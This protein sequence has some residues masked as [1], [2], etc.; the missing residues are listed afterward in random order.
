[1]CNKLLF[2]PFL[3]I[4]LLIF[5]SCGQSVRQG[6][7]MDD[8]SEENFEEYEENLDEEYD[9]E[10]DQ[11]DD[12]QEEGENEDAQVKRTVIDLSSGGGRISSSTYQMTLVIGTPQP[13]GTARGASHQTSVGTGAMLN[14]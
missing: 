14:Q 9:E 13:M 11:E 12:Y 2:L 5:T 3:G 6:E 4:F 1:M 10:D 7:I 8:Y